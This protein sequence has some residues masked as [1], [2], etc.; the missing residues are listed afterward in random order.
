MHLLTTVAWYSTWSQ[1]FGAC[2]ATRMQLEGRNVPCKQYCCASGL[3]QHLIIYAEDITAARCKGYIYFL[4]RRLRLPRR[5]TLERVPS[6][7]YFL[8]S[9]CGADM[10]PPRP[11][12]L[13]LDMRWDFKPFSN[14]RYLVCARDQKKADFLMVWSYQKMSYQ[15]RP[16][17]IT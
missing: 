17:L 8:F 14:K 4:G 9:A 12:P 10:L 13:Q 3:Q 11:P 15:K 7:W 2:T 6:D 1:S 5:V 16:F